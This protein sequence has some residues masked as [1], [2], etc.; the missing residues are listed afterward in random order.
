MTVYDNRCEIPFAD[1]PLAPDDP[2]SFSLQLH[3]HLHPV[4][5][6]P[7][8]PSPAAD[9]LLCARARATHVSAAFIFSTYFYTRLLKHGSQRVGV[10]PSRVVPPESPFLHPCHFLSLNYS[11]REI[12]L[13]EILSP[14]C[15]QS[16]A[17]CRSICH[18]I[19]HFLFFTHLCSSQFYVQST[20]ELAKN[21]CTH[22][23]SHQDNIETLIAIMN[24]LI[25]I[26]IR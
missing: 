12:T 22:F 1:P 9:R 16:F 10:A 6:S 21:G 24:Y 14:I 11:L 18:T 3:L 7:T 23:S 20:P 19:L 25:R 17:L 5:S 4:P 26:I 2:I 15:E 13:R 8:S